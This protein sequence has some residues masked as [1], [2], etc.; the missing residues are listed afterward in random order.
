MGRVVKNIDMT[1]VLVRDHEWGDAT[2]GSG[3]VWTH[4]Q[5]AEAYLLAGMDRRVLLALLSDAADAL[6]HVGNCHGCLGN[7]PEEYQALYRFLSTHLLR[8]D[9][10]DDDDG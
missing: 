3:P 1:A 8:L 10:T 7:G 4:D 6:Y 5:L 9:H 2:P